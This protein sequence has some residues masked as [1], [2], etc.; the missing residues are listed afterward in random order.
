MLLHGLVALHPIANTIV[1]EGALAAVQVVQGVEAS[2]G[3]VGRTYEADRPVDEGGE[4]V[5]LRPEVQ[6]SGTF[7]GEAILGLV[8]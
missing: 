6:L 3:Q 5:R 7:W 4:S 8:C 1:A 2:L